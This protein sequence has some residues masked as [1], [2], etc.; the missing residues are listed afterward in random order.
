MGKIDPK[1]KL[2][3][4]EYLH[5]F[6]FEQI[7]K[8]VKIEYKD[9]TPTQS[10]IEQYNQYLQK[11]QEDFQN[12]PTLY[13]KAIDWDI[14]RP[15]TKNFKKQLDVGQEFQVW[16][17]EEFK[18]FGI[19]I[20]IFYN[21]EGQFS[22]ECKL[23]IEIKNDARSKETGNIYFEVK[24]RLRS[25]GEW[26][27]SG[28]CKAD[29]SEFY[30]IGYPEKYY[31]F[32]KKDISKLY[33][34]IQKSLGTSAWVEGCYGVKEWHEENGK[35]VSTSEGFIMK[36]EKA[37]A[38]AYCHSIEEFI[39]KESKYVGVRHTGFYHVN[40]L[41]KW[42]GSGD[43]KDYFFEKKKAEEKYAPCKYCSKNSARG[44]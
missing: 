5:L 20:G 1:S 37:E 26:T 12:N 18:K 10:M 32:R 17:E 6:W 39:K 8:G 33:F 43:D 24:E 7:T 14:E 36:S 27:D 11:W 38:M 9:F 21:E 19:D 25:D 2:S 42:V 44:E 41:C 28:I 40:K 35:K 23:G 34:K 29:N 13:E 3:P 31:I 4:E 16:V 30:L 22:G 15:K